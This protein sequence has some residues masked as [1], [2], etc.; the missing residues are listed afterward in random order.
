MFPKLLEGISL[1]IG[2]CFLMHSLVSEAATRRPETPAEQKQRRLQD[3]L[4]RG[5]AAYVAIGSSLL[6][7]GLV[8]MMFRI[9]G[10]G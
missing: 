8:E 2:M 6:V 9:R 7:F 10:Q 3:R 5:R 4:R 1:V